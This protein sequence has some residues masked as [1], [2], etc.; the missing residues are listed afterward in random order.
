[1]D[2]WVYGCMDVWMNGCTHIF[3]LIKAMLTMFWTILILIMAGSF[4]MDFQLLKRHPRNCWNQL[5]L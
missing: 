3:I 5:A 1:M 2:V 4:V